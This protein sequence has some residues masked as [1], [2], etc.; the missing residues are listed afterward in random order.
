M[1]ASADADAL[2]MVCVGLEHAGESGSKPL[3]LFH[4]SSSFRVRLPE[5]DVRYDAEWQYESTIDG[6]D[7][8]LEEVGVL[9]LRLTHE[10]E[11]EGLLGVVR[12]HEETLSVGDFNNATQTAKSLTSLIA[13]NDGRLGDISDGERSLFIAP[14][15]ATPT[16]PR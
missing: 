11:R 9:S 8:L 5:D 14:A 1:P 12:R 6:D 13:A 3:R 7:N 4:I 2:E 10:Q 15:S 16:T